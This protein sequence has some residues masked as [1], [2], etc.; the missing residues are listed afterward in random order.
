M[1]RSATSVP[2]T[3]STRNAVVANT[4]ITAAVRNACRPASTSAAA[5]SARVWSRSRPTVAV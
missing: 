3:S 4:R 1:P 2:V 5:S